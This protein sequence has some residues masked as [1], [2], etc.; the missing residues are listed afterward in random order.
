L[1]FQQENLTSIC[2]SLKE[3][4]CK[5]FCDVVENKSKFWTDPSVIA[6]IL[7]HFRNL[8]KLSHNCSFYQCEDKV[9][10]GVV[11]LLDEALK[12]NTGITSMALTSETLGVIHLTINAPFRGITWI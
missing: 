5:N 7:R 1:E 6:F 4:G 10:S 11:A 2:S 8:Q 3:F 12:D 9:S